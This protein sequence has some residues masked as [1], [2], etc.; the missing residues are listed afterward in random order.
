MKYRSTRGGVADV[1]FKQAVMMGLANDGGLLVPHSVPDV[2]DKL[3][4]WDGLSFEALATRLMS[5]YIDDI[6]AD[7]L[8]A[9]IDESY[10]RFDHEQITPVVPVDDFYVLELYHGP[11]L[12]FKDIALQFLGN[13]F[14]YI[15]AEQNGR[16][17]LLGATSGDT[18]SAAI[19]AI[20]GKSNINIFILFPEGKTS[21]V[22]EMQMTTVLDPNV[23]N[24]A[25]DGSF[26]DCQLLI[27]NTFSDLEYKTKYNLG[28]VNSVNWARVLAQIV[29]Y[30]YAWFQLS[31]P[32]A[33]DV[34][35][36]T[37]NFGNIFAG[38]LAR[39]MGLP[40]NKLILAAN[41]NDILPRF[42]TDG[43]YE[44]GEVFFTESPAMDIQV[45]SNFERYLYYQLGGSCEKV[46]EFMTQFAESGVARFDFN[47][48]GFDDSFRA[49][50][51]SDAQ[52]LETIR[53]IYEKDDYLI[54]PH[55]AV[56]IRVGRQLRTPGIPLLCLSTAHPAK[57]EGAI[58]RAVPGVVPHHPRLQALVGLPVRKENMVAD[59]ATVKEF[60]RRHGV[61]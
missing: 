61:T 59:D 7:D 4:D 24:I 40:I 44:R 16:L 58:S 8:S 33:F 43:V 15:L 30:F 3:D 5:E 49:G 18:G 12:A 53:G 35:V 28:A 14:Q 6:P 45:S 42:F 54:D 9:L 51:V 25:V 29:Y 38:C 41:S 10:A 2:T 20:R 11:T 27:K 26:D 37:G 32:K 17:N 48:R 60:I 55:T 1:S 57:F 36:P 47:T 56:G 19:E 34:A 31:R 39:R 52:T 22:Q 13:L 50:S 23:Y 21:P 46:A